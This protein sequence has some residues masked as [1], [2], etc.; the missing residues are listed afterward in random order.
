[1][2]KAIIY[3]LFLI[4]SGLFSSQPSN[5]YTLNVD[6]EFKDIEGNTLKCQI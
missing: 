6:F 1:M 4:V 2:F 5:A 3:S